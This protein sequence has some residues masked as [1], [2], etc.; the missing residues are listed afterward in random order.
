MTCARLDVEVSTPDMGWMLDIGCRQT[1]KVHGVLRYISRAQ[2]LN[3]VMM[4]K[5]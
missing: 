4:M 2:L 5:P 3:M 1:R